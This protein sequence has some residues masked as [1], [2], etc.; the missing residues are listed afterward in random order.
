[1]NQWREIFFRAIW[2]WGKVM[3]CFYLFCIQGHI[4]L[5]SPLTVAMFVKDWQLY[6]IL[7]I[8]KRL[9]LLF[10]HP[11]MSNSLQTHGLQHTRPPSPSSGVCSIN[12]Q[13]QLCRPAISSSDV[14]FSFC[15]QSFP[16][17]GTFWMSG[18]FTSDDQNTVV[19]VSVL[20]VNIQDLPPLR[21]TGLISLLS[22]ELSGVFSSSTVWRHPFFGILLLYGQALTTVHDHWEDYMD[23][24]GLYG[25]W[26]WLYGHFLAE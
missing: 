13:H 19:S 21:L 2:L 24:P 23:L 18:M 15:P 26:P 16:T 11:V 20:P 7:C 5:T 17:S 22:K 8:G 6:T 25:H 3:I 9:L 14:L 10:S 1:M 4:Y 12:I